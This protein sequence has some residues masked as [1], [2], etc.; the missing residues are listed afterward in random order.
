MAEW[1]NVIVN[2]YSL[3]ICILMTLAWT[4]ITTVIA[5]CATGAKWRH[6]QKRLTVYESGGFMGENMTA[7]KAICQGERRDTCICTGSLL[8]W[9][10]S[11]RVALLNNRF[12]VDWCITTLNLQEDVTDA[13]YDV[14]A[15]LGD[16]QITG[17][18]PYLST[19]PESI[20]THFSSSTKS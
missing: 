17:S 1:G 19:L 14:T 15:S 9:Y 11:V 12:M 18:G 13:S 5:I 8:E 16:W 4:V 10:N 3:I 2:G 6:K 7:R 20:N